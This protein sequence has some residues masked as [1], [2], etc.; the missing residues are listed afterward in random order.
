MNLAVQSGDEIGALTG[1]FNVMSRKISELIEESAKKAHLESEIAIASTVQQTLIPGPNFQDNKIKITSHYQAASQC[2]GDWWG[3]FEVGNKLTIMIADATGHGFPSALITAAAR[4]C[5]S[6]IHK[7]AQDT[8]DYVLSPSKMLQFANRSIYEAGNQKIMM[9][10]FIGVIDFEN[11]TITY[12]SA[13][14]NPP[15]LFKR[16]GAAF[17]LKS[18]M[19]TGM[20][21]GESQTPPP[22]EEKSMP[23][24]RG[25]MIFLYTDGLMEGRSSAGEMFGKKRVRKVVEANLA[26][27]SETAVSSLMGEFLSYNAGKELDDDVTV[28]LATLLV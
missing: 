13:G 10:F 25:D 12:S 6:V 16:D 20:R 27:G 2:G 26:Q 7:I 18:M 11:R 4:S 24:E 3:F 19:A 1:S 28:A 23:L 9:T 17:T 22:F 5:F 14:H 15:W 8:P 21:L